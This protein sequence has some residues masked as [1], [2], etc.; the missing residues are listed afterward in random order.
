MDTSYF[1]YVPPA[2][3]RPA[4]F[5][6]PLKLGPSP[7]G[8]RH[9][10]QAPLDNQ[11][12]IVQ[13]VVSNLAIAVT[14]VTTGFITADLVRRL[15]EAASSW[16]SIGWVVAYL[17]FSAAVFVL[18]YGGLVYQVSRLGYIL[19]RKRHLP[20]TQ[21]ALDQF[22]D[23][24]DAPTVTILVPSFK[25]S[26][27]A[28]S[29][30]LLSAALQDYPRKRVVLLI[31]DPPDPDDHADV[32]LLHA[33]RELPAK[34]Q[35]SMDDAR[36]TFER[37]GEDA[38]TESDSGLEPQHLADAFETAA[39]WFEDR[40]RQTPVRNHTD[41]LFVRIVLT[42]PARDLRRRASHFAKLASIQSGEAERAYQG[43]AQRFDVE[44]TTFERK[45]FVNLSHEPNKAMNL[46]TYIGLFGRS[47][48]L[49][50]QE[51]GLHCV[52]ARSG[53]ADFSVQRPDYVVTLDADSMLTHR[54]LLRLVEVLERP[55]NERMAVAQSPYS[56]VPGAPNAVE[57]IAGATTDIMY[58]WQQGSTWLNATYWIGANAVIRTTA[59]EDIATDGA[60]RGFP[61]TRFIQDRTLIEDTESTV[62]I[63]RRGWELHN[64]PERLAYSATPPD[65][66][67]LIIQRRR[68]ANG[69]LI[70][71]PKLLR[72]LFAPAQRRLSIIGEAF[73]RIHYVIS[74]AA[75]NSAIVIVFAVPLW[76]GIFSWWIPLS[77]AP[78]FA[79]YTL[80]LKREG[81]RWSD[82][83]RVYAM[84][85]LLV[86][87]NLAGMFNSLR[88]ALTGK[89]VPFG[90]T[91]KV[92]GR[93]VA[94]AVYIAT[95]YALVTMLAA[96]ATLSLIQGHLLHGTFALGNA[97]F[98]VFA[99]VSFIG[100]RNGWQDLRAAFPGASQPEANAAL[101]PAGGSS[102]EA[103]PS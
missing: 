101:V 41:A 61:V 31:D 81:Y 78:Y 64:Y 88:Q 47:L 85:L 17:G 45:R 73:M 76:T 95:E 40:A 60:E 4:L 25:E 58:V 80:D 3:P 103:P 36:S 44:L 69:G 1:I 34:I 15:S 22:S 5:K 55:G 6:D 21:R 28:V 11:S 102:V 8:H 84:N 97:V 32:A 72:Y 23:R 67:S 100:L 89:K 51:D 7:N 83:L 18:I 94:P 91:P 70:I 49:E 56:A 98:L 74:E 62:D 13:L 66:G 50:P 2:G 59:L 90:R 57:R 86:P 10:G 29:Q 96:G 48:R 68:W 75:V 43:L 24:R 79:L 9:E 92:A 16:Q 39:A 38:G 77:A 54:Y 52:D 63:I 71:L 65:F 12:A 27:E 35:A 87:V 14:L 19:R 20:Q 99:I 93:V 82:M 46:N 30:T 33:M 26:P 53:E 42:E 37:L